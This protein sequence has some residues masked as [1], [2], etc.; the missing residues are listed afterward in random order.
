[1]DRLTSA[2]EAV[3]VAEVVSVAKYAGAYAVLQYLAKKEQG[4]TRDIAVLF[5]SL[6]EAEQ[7]GEKFPL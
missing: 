2:E 4:V 7:R 1:M 6:V 3:A 5:G